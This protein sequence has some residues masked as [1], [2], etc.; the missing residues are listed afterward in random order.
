MA[1]DKTFEF[2]DKQAMTATAVSTVVHENTHS[3]TDAWG[4]SISNQIGG[5]SFN[6]A[7]TT[8]LTSTGTMAITLVTK[9]A[10]ASLSASGT[11]LATINVSAAAAAGTKY[12]VILPAGTERLKYLGA[13]L[14]ESGSISAGNCNVWLGLKN[15]VID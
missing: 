6:V 9:T 12:S 14:T 11:T 5:M 8:T 15:E 3:S 2:S 1:L 13:L 10:D 4:S 7:I